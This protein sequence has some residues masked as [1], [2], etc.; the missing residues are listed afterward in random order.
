MGSKMEEA[1]KELANQKIAFKE[2]AKELDEQKAELIKN[3]KQNFEATLA[4]KETELIE[5]KEAE[6]AEQRKIIE[7]KEAKLAE[8]AAE[9]AE[10]TENLNQLTIDGNEFSNKVTKELKTLQNENNDQKNLLSA[11]QDTLLENES[12]LR[13]AK[14]ERDTCRRD[15]EEAED[16]LVK[17]IEELEKLLKIDAM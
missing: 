16:L 17:E 4:E 3:L 14:T 9:L 2:H 15:L 5:K 7:E 10:Q 6:L 11:A 8:Q 12:E 1:E 13:E